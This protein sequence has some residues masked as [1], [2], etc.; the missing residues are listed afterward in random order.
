MEWFRELAVKIKGL[1][2]LKG[3]GCIYELSRES[4]KKYILTAQHCLTNDLN[5]RSFDKS[6][7]EE[8]EI[9]DL[10]GI[11]L[12]VSEIYIP[13]NTDLDFAVIETFS[14]K[15][16]KSIAIR[17]PKR[18]MEYLFYGF[19]KYLEYDADP[20][21]LLEG[22]ILEKNGVHLKLQNKYGNLSDEDGDATD[23]TIGFSGSGIYIQ[24]DEN[25][26]LIGIL[27]RLRSGGTHGRLVGINILEVNSFLEEKRLDILLPYELSDFKVYLKLLLQD[28]DERFKHALNK[29]YNNFF[30]GIL[31]GD[32]YR[33]L[34]AKLFLPYDNNGNILNGKLWEGWLR[35]LLYISLYKGERLNSD[36]I[37]EY[38]YIEEPHQSRNRFYYTEEMRLATFV[39]HL[40]EKPYE[41]I[42]NNDLIFVNSEKFRGA[43][44]FS[45]NDIHQIIQTIDNPYIYEN[46]IDITNPSELKKFKIIHLDYLI[47]QVEQEITRCLVLQ[48]SIKEVEKA[49]I[50]CLKEIF[51]E[52]EKTEI[53]EKRAL[54]SEV[55]N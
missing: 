1:D 45:F 54:L 28:E 18:N 36:N 27:V 8:I 42:H 33:K 3:S 6:E 26:Y 5:K 29:Q 17:K 35:F 51:I 41:D 2:D 4:G 31:P 22:H 11:R 34:D 50:Q 37:N 43:K 7:R 13:D 12:H 44:L 30:T 53:Y 46:G 55:D 48:K 39:K 47:D 10:S 9:F 49:C 19:P 24:E 38:I 40:Y 16:Y 52:I 20:G 14:S 15:I 32:I 21:E 25:N 23:N